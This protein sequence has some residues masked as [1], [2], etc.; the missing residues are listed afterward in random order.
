MVNPGGQVKVLPS[1]TK[2][3]FAGVGI[4]PNP[5]W[6][7]ATSKVGGRIQCGGIQNIALLSGG[8]T[9]AGGSAIFHL[10]I[11]CHVACRVA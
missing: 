7:P 10:T 6:Q 8:S 1:Y 4:E 3:E 11:A 2:N 5:V 9:G